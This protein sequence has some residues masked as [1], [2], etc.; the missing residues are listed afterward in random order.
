[1]RRKG[2]GRR[3][4]SARAWKKA[5]RVP[6]WWRGVEPPQDSPFKP[7]RFG[8]TRGRPFPIPKQG[9]WPY[10]A[11]PSPNGDAPCAGSW[12]LGF[13]SG[14]LHLPHRAMQANSSPKAAH[15]ATAGACTKPPTPVR[16]SAKNQKRE[17]V[18]L[19]RRLSGAWKADPRPVNLGSATRAGAP[20]T[21]SGPRGLAHPAARAVHTSARKPF[22]P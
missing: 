2:Q 16:P 12:E 21:R 17:V 10:A 20:I 7:R 11:F 14:A 3:A 9:H 4:L 22:K 1:M 19:A 6:A 18:S 15:C 5:W 8:E 13:C